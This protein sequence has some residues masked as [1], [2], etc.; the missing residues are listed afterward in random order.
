MVS[1]KLTVV[2]F[3]FA[4]ALAPI[5]VTVVGR[6]R[7]VIAVPSNALAPILV[8]F[9]GTKLK[10]VME[11]QPLNIESGISV[12]SLGNVMF[13]WVRFVQF[14]SKPVPSVVE[15]DAILTEVMLE[16]PLN[17]VFP[18]LVTV[19]GIVKSVKALEQ[20]EKAEVPIVVTPD[21]IVK[22]SKLEQPEK[23]ESV[24][25]VTPLGI[26]IVASVE[27]FMKACFPM[28]VIVSGREIDV[29]AEQR[30]NEP[31]S[32]V[33]SCELAPIFTVASL[34]QP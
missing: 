11:V 21:G 15:V 33:V 9:V 16:H 8:T 3:V 27:Q 10:S 25:S 2:N 1:G 31:G 30:V 28:L 19:A 5:L 13:D 7:S 12:I 24:I 14:W 26:F 22:F 32:T 29:R 20:V 23:Q 4:N 34:V 6:F 18:T 17:A